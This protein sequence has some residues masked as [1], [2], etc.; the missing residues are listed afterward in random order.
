MDASLKRQPTHLFE[1]LTLALGSGLLLGPDGAEIELRPKSLELLHHLVLNAGQVVT[2]EVLLDAIWPNVTVSDESV[3]QCVRDIRRALGDDAQRLVRTVPKR[4]YMLTAEV[5]E[6]AANAS[7]RSTLPTAPPARKDAFCHS[8][9][10]AAL[11]DP[12][13]DMGGRH[14]SDGPGGRGRNWRSDPAGGAARSAA[15]PCCGAR[16][17]Y[18]S[19]RGDTPRGRGYGPVRARGRTGGLAARA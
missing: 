1:G 16:R 5:V 6:V 19:R 2:R 11:T 8:G 3:T 12:D 17:L 9:K 14:G 13:G 4:G 18:R 7:E 15:G 10:D